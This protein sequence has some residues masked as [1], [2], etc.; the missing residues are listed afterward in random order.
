MDLHRFFP[1]YIFIFA[2]IIRLTFL[3]GSYQDKEQVPYWEDVTIAINFLEGKGYAYN[4]TMIGSNP[5]TR[6]TAV[7]TPV[8]PFLVLLVFFFFGMKNFFALFLVHALLSSFTC[9]LLFL[10]I[11]KFSRSIAL[12]ASVAF[13]VYPPFIHHSVT[14]PESTTLALFLISIFFYELVSLYETFTPKR[15]ILAGITSGILAMTEPM[16][17]PF[18][19]LTFF[20]IACLALSSWKKIFV[21]ILLV[22][23]VFAVTVAPWTIRNYLVFKEFVF[24]KSSFGSTLKTSMAYSGI[25]LPEEVW[26]SL[27][28]EVEG[29]DEVNED[30]AVKKAVLS[31]IA[32]NPIAYLQL[33]PKNFLDFWWEI[34]RYKN[35]RSIK[36]VFGRKIPYILLLVSSIPSMLWGLTHFGTS[37]RLNIKMHVFQN[38][39]FILIFTFTVEYTIL[40][41]WNLRYHFPVELA[42]LVFCAETILFTINKVDFTYSSLTPTLNTD[43]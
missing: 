26:L 11:D 25:R 39:M 7:K 43:L 37:S 23:I 16:T 21:E 12:I 22:T 17:I 20:Y 41:A 33:L 18:I 14:I 40:G 35:D 9:W 31:W 8:F 27:R 10:S 15:W 29:M 38:I 19:F 30:K 2:L 24:I 42:M 36:Y 1:L 4:F 32:A 6:S 34:E 28:K 3:L 5:P 13:A